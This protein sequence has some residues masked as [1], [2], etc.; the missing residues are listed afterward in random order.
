MHSFEVVVER[1]SGGAS[2]VHLD[3][4]ITSLG[5]AQD[6]QIVLVDSAVSEHHGLLRAR[7]NIL[8]VEDCGNTS[9]VRV[10]GELVTRKTLFSGDTVFVGS[11]KIYVKEGSRK[12]R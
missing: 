3:Q 10:N 1:A 8:M 4:G 11:C 6:N 12:P 7:M 5:C 9:G 2:V